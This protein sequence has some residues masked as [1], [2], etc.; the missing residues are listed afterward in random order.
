MLAALDLEKKIRIEVDMSDY[1]IGG[2][3]SMECKDKK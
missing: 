2:V 1:A 3:L